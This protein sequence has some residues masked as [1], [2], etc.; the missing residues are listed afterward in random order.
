[1]LETM[2]KNMTWILWITIGLITVTFLFF[3][4]YP[5]SKGEGAMAMVDGDVITVEEWN[6]VYQNMSEQYRQI[7]KDQFNDNFAKTIR[8]QALQELINN[9]LLIREAE[10]MGITVTDEELQQ[11]ILSI[12]A[13]SPQGRFDRRT[14]ELYLSRVNLKPAAFEANQRE[15]LLRRKLEQLVE[16]G[17]DV[18]DAE[19]EAAYKTRNPK[20]KAGDLQKNKASFKQSFLSEKKR[21]ALDGFTAGLRGKA[22]IKIKE[23]KRGIG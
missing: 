23:E 16:D 2:R 18:S 12:S 8:S 22:K 1:M 7:L 11:S 20:A 9:R 14:Y 15:Y 17:V 13:F 19:L 6:R 21:A 10:R 4:V 3:G 5:A